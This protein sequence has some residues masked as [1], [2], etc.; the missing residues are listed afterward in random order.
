MS[1]SPKTRELLDHFA[2]EV[3]LTIK[4]P[5]PDQVH[6]LRVA[7]RRLTQALVVVAPESKGAK[8]TRR[9]LKHLMQLAGNVRDCDINLKLAG[10]LGASQEFLSRLHRRRAAAERL[11]NQELQNWDHPGLMSEW[12]EK[13]V[14]AT[15]SA[16]AH[17]AI[18]RAV[19]RLFKRGTAAEESDKKLH[20]LRIAAK[21]LRYTLDLLDHCDQAHL[22]QI[23]ELQTRLGDINDYE[24]ACRIAG[25]ESASKR[26]IGKLRAKQERKIA[27]FHRY[28]QK[29]FSGK[30]SEWEQVTLQAAPSRSRRE[31]QGAA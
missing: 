23:K 25:E 27:S 19:K 22:Q 29:E 13:L 12:K 17:A 4:T 24:T 7:I 3:R 1:A 5:E 31:R 28:W 26:L 11:L 20:P 18:L 6:N 14:S 21:K 10:K 30:K 8:K 16:P 2:S 15:A 9:E